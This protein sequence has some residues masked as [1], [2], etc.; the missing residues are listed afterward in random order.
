MFL[1]SHCQEL[2]VN[3]NDLRFKLENDRLRKKNRNGLRTS[4]VMDLRQHLCGLIH[5]QSTNKIKPKAMKTKVKEDAKTI[6]KK[7][8]KAKEALSSETK[9]VTNSSKKNILKN[10]VLIF[11]SLITFYFYVLGTLILTFERFTNH[12]L[13]VLYA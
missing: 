12:Y 2:K 7:N 6:K 9:K 3:V 5:S 13:N 1:I 11:H 10:V 8:L 4:G